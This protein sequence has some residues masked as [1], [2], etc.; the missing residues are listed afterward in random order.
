[1]L[2][3]QS[4]QDFTKPLCFIG[5]TVFYDPKFRV[6]YELA[7]WYRNNVRLHEQFSFVYIFEPDWSPES[8]DLKILRR[9][10][11]LNYGCPFLIFPANQ[12]LMVTKTILAGAEYI[13]APKFLDAAKAKKLPASL[14]N[15]VKWIMEE[16]TSIEAR[17]AAFTF[18][19]DSENFRS[20][21]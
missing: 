14:I 17:F 19:Q 7:S 1:M 15:R 4:P 3:N 2:Y 12:G 10:M 11:L 9:D 20:A 5:E 6:N 18:L 8:L 13:Y 16:D 21:S